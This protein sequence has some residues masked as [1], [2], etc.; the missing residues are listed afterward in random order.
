VELNKKRIL[1]VDDDFDIRDIFDEILTGEGYE[2]KSASN[3]KEAMSMLL[4]LE[5]KNLPDLIILDSQMPEMNGAQFLKAIRENDSEDLKRI[6]ILLSSG[7]E[8]NADDEFPKDIFRM[9][10]PVEF[11]GLIESVSRALR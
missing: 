7:N 6:S 1:L 8:P 10:K 3:G 2:V 11:T 9:V 5:V 4:A